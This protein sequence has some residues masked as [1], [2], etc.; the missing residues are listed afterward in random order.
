ME[1]SKAM[2][3]MCA[4][5]SSSAISYSPVSSPMTHARLRWLPIWNNAAYI[6]QTSDRARIGAV[7]GVTVVIL[8]MKCG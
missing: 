6:Y 4:T 7:I 5:R 2:D 8:V 1:V 3:A